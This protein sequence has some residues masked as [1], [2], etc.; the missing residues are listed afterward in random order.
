MTYCDDVS[1]RA[2]HLI[3]VLMRTR[4]LS[5]K[6]KWF[7]LKNCPYKKLVARLL[8]LAFNNNIFRLDLSSLNQKKTVNLKGADQRLVSFIELNE[9]FFAERISA[10]KLQKRMA[11]IMRVLHVREYAF[12][13]DLLSGGTAYLDYLSYKK[14]FLKKEPDN[15]VRFMRPK[16]AD[17][18]AAWGG[19]RFVIQP[20]YQGIQMRLILQ[21]GK[22]PKLIAGDQC[23]YAGRMKAT[24]NT[25][26]EFLAESGLN[27]VEFDAMLV[28]RDKK[29]RPKLDWKAKECNLYVYDWIDEKTP[30]KKRLKTVGAFCQ[31][32]K[33]EKN[34]RILMMPT[35]IIA[36]TSIGAAAKS[37][38]RNANPYVS[39]NGILIKRW[40][41]GYVHKRSSDWLTMMPIKDDY[42]GD[43]LGRAT[44]IGLNY[45]YTK[46][47]GI[48]NNGLELDIEGPQSLLKDLTKYIGYTSEYAYY[49]GCL[50]HRRV[51]YDKGREV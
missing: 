35:E 3:A 30:L 10:K 2:G 20:N 16:A 14:F 36:G 48:D 12:Y 38:S 4:F 22:K 28:Q 6:E 40:D 31:F 39:R 42:S 1:E 49:R 23:N 44:I 41:S 27:R 43:I 13:E 15:K 7:L 9:A 51:L 11:K 33:E 18:E 45:D 34:K 21:Q 46:I 19:K 25:A 47:I 37:F 8:G 26:Q 5:L 29:D 17:P 24:L 50:R 32:M